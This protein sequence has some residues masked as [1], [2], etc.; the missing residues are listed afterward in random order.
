MSKKKK[1]EIT[2]TIVNNPNG[3]L[4]C[5]SR[6]PIEYQGQQYRT[7]EA[8]FQVLRFDGFP[9]IQNEIR[10]CPSPM[11]AK[12]IARRERALLNRTGIWDYAESDRALM[13][14]CLSLKLEQHPDLKMQLISTGDAI[15]IEDCTTH[16]REAARI[17]GAVKVNDKWEGQNI[18]GQLWMELR[19]EL[20]D[21]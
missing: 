3:W 18:L 6:Y 15:I 16:D 12:M 17:W 11:W 13:K 21:Q 10:N 1:R 5:M 14:Q 7:C 8:L 19:S 20:L 4:S 2:I 9:N